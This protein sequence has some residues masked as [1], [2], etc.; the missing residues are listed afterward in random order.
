MHA[1][2]TRFLVGMLILGAFAVARGDEEGLKSG[3]Q[4]GSKQKP[5]F[6]PASFQVWMV[7]GAR[8]GRYHSPVCENGLN[9][10][11]IIFVK[12]LDT[13]DKGLVKL[14]KRMDTLMAKHGDAR[15]GCC[16]VV[17]ND[18]GFRDALD[19]EDDDITKKLAEAASYKDELGKKLIDLTKAEKMEHIHLALDTK[20]GPKDFELNDEAKTTIV[21]Y[22][23][24]IV[25]RSYAFK[26]QIKEEDADRI[27]SEIEKVV[28]E[29]ERLSR[30]TY[31]NKVIKK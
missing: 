24:H 1:I 20:G 7:T 6:V 28:L 19:K 2:V 10:A 5:S 25:L 8:A 16:M 9:P 12:E 18:G 22:N 14:L 3:P 31:R 21:F 26:D 30:P 4:P 15:F 11:A 23:R 17:L 29:V 27:A 13:E